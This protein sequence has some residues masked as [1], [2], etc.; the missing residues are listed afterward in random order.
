MLKEQFLV[1]CTCIAV[2]RVLRIAEITYH[3]IVQ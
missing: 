2:H 3:M 1:G